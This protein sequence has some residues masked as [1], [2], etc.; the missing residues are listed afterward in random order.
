MKYLIQENN[1][2]IFDPRNIYYLLGSNI[3]LLLQG[4]P[5][6]FRFIDQVSQEALIPV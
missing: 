5:F 6:L 4:E 2:F 3:K 1:N